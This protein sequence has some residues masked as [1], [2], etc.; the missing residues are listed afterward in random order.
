MCASQEYRNLTG[1]GKRHTWHKGC[2]ENTVVCVVK[3]H[4][5]GGGWMDGWG[6]SRTMMLGVGH[7]CCYA[8]R[9]QCQPCD[10]GVQ[11]KHMCTPHGRQRVRLSKKGRSSFPWCTKPK[12]GSH[13]SRKHD[14]HCHACGLRTHSRT[15]LFAN[16]R[17]RMR[18]VV[19]RKLQEGCT[20]ASRERP[21]PD[22]FSEKRQTRCKGCRE[23]TVGW[24][25]KS[26]G[27]RF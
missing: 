10:V 25:V 16:I 18:R 20:C 13:H 9:T 15:K 3:S 5:G 2:R 17:T 4:T 21:K 8:M 11:S 26:F 22:R 14:C 12:Q 1:S 7:W 23:N 19:N 27:V 6:G 24:V